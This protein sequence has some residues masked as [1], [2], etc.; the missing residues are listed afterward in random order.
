[1][2]ERPALDFFAAT[3]LRFTL[4]RAAATFAFVA[5]GLALA[6]R[7]TFALATFARTTR[8]FATFA[9]ATLRCAVRR[10]F[11]FAAIESVSPRRGCA[12]GGRRRA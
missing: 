9:F 1:V 12:H 6:A 3:T 4:R 8:R 10:A 7:A 5:T 2:A 11:F